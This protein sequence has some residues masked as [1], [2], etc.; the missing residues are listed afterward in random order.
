MTFQLDFALP[1]TW[2]MTTL[3]FL[4]ELINGDRGKNYP[5]RKA[6]CKDGIPFVNAGDL[7]NG[8]ISTE[9][10]GFISPA[11]FDILRSGKFGIGDV[12]YCIRGSL[13]KVAFNTNLPTGAIA[14]SLII[15]RPN[16]AISSKYVFYYLMSP[17]AHNMIQKFDNGTAQPNLSGADL[18]RFEIPIPGLWNQQKIVAKIEELFSQLDRGIQNLTTARQQL[19]AYRQAVLKHAFEGNL[20]RDWRADNSNNETGVELRKRILN[21]RRHEWEKAERA[22]LNQLDDPPANDRWKARYPEPEGFD[23]QDLP[24]LPVVWC[25]VGLDELVSGRPRSLQS[26][27]FGSNLRHS[28]FGASGVLVLG[29]DNVRDGTF[30]MGSQNRISIEKFRE[31]EKYQA[32]PGDLLI[33]VMASLGRTCV[34]PRDLEKAVITKH[35]YRVSME[36]DLLYPE[37]FNL[38]LQ[39]QTVSRLRMFKNAQGQTR[40][41]LNSSILKVLPLPLC[42]R[43]EQVEIVSRL[44]S[45]LSNVDDAISQIDDQ[46]SR[47]TTLRHS[48]LKRAFSGHL[49]DQDPHDEPASVLLARIKAKKEER[50][51]DPESNNKSNKGKKEAA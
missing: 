3:G 41:G 29:I 2:R 18:A 8:I 49:V 43:A 24:D 17:L 32:R 4:C 35:V 50:S 16:E 46:L 21:R 6:L 36:E 26:G 39:S 14:S 33:T 9:R 10:L 19:K 38:L 48:I 7:E 12:L 34:V 44:S 1:D 31:L 20:T 45:Q 27:P 25:W 51:G 22:R 5:G 13:G 15:V 28:E 11:T 40:P 47:A 30:S 23:D 37:Y 42:S